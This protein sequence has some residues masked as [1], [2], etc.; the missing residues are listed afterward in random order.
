MENTIGASTEVDINSLLNPD[1]VSSSRNLDMGNQFFN[2]RNFTQDYDPKTAFR[3]RTEVEK[4]K[5]NLSNERERSSKATKP[6]VEQ[7]VA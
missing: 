6:D 7:E 2:K 3:V 4:S 5:R 1:R